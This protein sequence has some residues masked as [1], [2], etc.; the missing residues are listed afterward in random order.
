MDCDIEFSIIERTLTNIFEIGAVMT[1][2]RKSK[3]QKAK[4]TNADQKD[5]TVDMPSA[6]KPESDK[7][8]TNVE[9][10]PL[11]HEEKRNK[12]YVPKSFKTFLEDANLPV[13]TEKKNRGRIN[14]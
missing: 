13:I 12:E 1:R 7:N 9:G 10:N 8:L 5:N 6:D 14:G 2:K 11:Y 3:T 4:I